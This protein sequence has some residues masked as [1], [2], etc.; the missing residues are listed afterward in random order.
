MPAGV[1]FPALCEACGAAQCSSCT[2]SASD[3]YERATMGFLPY[4][5]RQQAPSAAEH[6]DYGC[7]H[8]RTPHADVPVSRNSSYAKDAHAATPV[9]RA[10]SII[11]FVRSSFTSDVRIRLPPKIIFVRQ[12]Y[13]SG[14]RLT[15]RLPSSA[16]LPCPSSPTA[17]QRHYVQ[18]AR[19]RRLTIDG[20]AIQHLD[21]AGRTQVKR[22]LNKRNDLL[23]VDL[24]RTDVSTMMDTGCLHLPIAYAKLNLAR[25]ASPLRQCSSRHSATYAARSRPS[26]DPCPKRTA[27]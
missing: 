21:D 23:I 24:A 13:F 18:S 25:S 4:R 5:S 6:R 9:A 12:P 1:H 17:D 10:K 7:L 14:L 11:F 22:L 20:T 15:A 2:G 27:A 16:V 8:A 3:P 19:K 26:W